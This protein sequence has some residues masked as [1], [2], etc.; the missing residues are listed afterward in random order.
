MD[1]QELV[2]LAER[3][4]RKMVSYATECVSTLGGMKDMEAAAHCAIVAAHLR[5][6][7][8]APDHG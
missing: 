1:R 3:V 6:L 7:T 2:A 5:T 4:E 8:K